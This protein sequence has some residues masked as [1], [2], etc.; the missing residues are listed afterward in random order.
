MQNNL[1]SRA[2]ASLKQQPLVS[3][4]SLIGSALAIFLIMVV[5]MTVNLPY[6]DLRPETNKDRWLACSYTTISNNNWGDGFNTSN[7]ATSFKTIKE[8]IYSLTTPEEV[9]AFGTGFTT[10]PIA[11]AGGTPVPVLRKDVDD[12]FFKVFDFDWKSGEP[13]TREQFDSGVPMVVISASVAKKLFGN[14]DVTGR[15]VELDHMPYRICGVVADVPSVSHFA[16]GDVWVPFTATTTIDDVWNDG[17]MG[18]LSAL[19]LARDKADFPA[20]REEYGKMLAK[21][22]AQI[23]EAGWEIKRMGRP[24]DIEEELSAPWANQEPDVKALRKRH[25]ITYAILLLVPAVN[26]S[27][28]TNSRLS[29][30]A[31]E[32][33]VRRAFGATRFEIMSDLF[34]ENLVITVAAGLVGWLLSMIF[35]LLFKETFFSATWGADDITGVSVGSL[36]QWST[37]GWAL[38]FCFLLNLLSAG[39]PALQASRTN[40]VNALSGKK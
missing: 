9:T 12:R 33:G 36:M 29:R 23:G 3:A 25:L 26:L 15:Q 7:G 2:F 32:I 18:M 10:T 21:Y 14:T 16:Y 20:I 19:I 39:I 37:F 11:A 5:V 22:N 13:F 24:Y 1:I 27:S 8:T 4:L 6:S 40:I 35:A 31:K 34:M 28:M 38:F 30:R 17:Y